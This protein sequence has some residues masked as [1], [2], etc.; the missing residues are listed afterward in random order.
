MGKALESVEGYAINGCHG[1][2][3]LFMGRMF[4]FGFIKITEGFSL[5]PRKVGEIKQGLEKLK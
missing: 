2:N 1:N 5:N 3:A 4:Y